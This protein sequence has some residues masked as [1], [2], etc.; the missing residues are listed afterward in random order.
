MLS[1]DFLLDP[2]TFT[3]QANGD[4]EQYCLLY[5]I[6]KYTTEFLFFTHRSQAESIELFTEVKLSCGGMIWLPA[7]PF[8]SP[9][10]VS[11]QSSKIINNDS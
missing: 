8:P 10:L 5:T 3:R 7:H 11:K 2:V 9:S 1:L 6:I 4:P